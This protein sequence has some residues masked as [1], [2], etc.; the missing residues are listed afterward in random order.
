MG[1]DLGGGGG[2]GKKQKAR[3]QPSMNVTPLVDVVLVLLIIFMVITPMMVR[4]FWTHVPKEEKPSD[5]AEAEK[6]KADAPVPVVLS[7]AADGTVRINKDVV[8]RAELPTKLERIFA[9]RADR[10]VFFDADDQMSYGQAVE[11]LDLARS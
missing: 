8:K 3:V 5:S 4:Q 11:V 6:D 10:V 1:F 9:A 2:S 7:V